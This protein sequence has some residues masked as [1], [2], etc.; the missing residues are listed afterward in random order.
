MFHGATPD[1]DKE[2]ILTDFTKPNSRTRIVIATIA[3]GLGIDIADV[4]IV[5]NWGLPT[6]MLQYWQEVKKNSVCTRHFACNI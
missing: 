5:V 3:F 4:R 1:T 6:N 2:R